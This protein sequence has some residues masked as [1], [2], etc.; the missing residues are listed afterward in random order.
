MGC[1]EAKQ[2]MQFWT[3]KKNLFN[4]KGR[5]KVIDLVGWK[6]YHKAN[7]SQKIKNLT[8]TSKIQEYISY[9]IANRTWKKLNLWNTYQPLKFAL[10]NQTNWPL[11]LRQKSRIK[12][13]YAS[14]I[15]LALFCVFT[16]IAWHIAKV[17]Y[18]SLF[19][20]ICGRIKEMCNAISTIVTIDLLIKSAEY[21]IEQ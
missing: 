11:D 20:H 7:W 3:R 13:N 17:N 5:R 21:T 15:F 12:S 8:C 2:C 6:P 14:K 4:Y 10:K 1:I 9:H 16:K 18:L 19:A